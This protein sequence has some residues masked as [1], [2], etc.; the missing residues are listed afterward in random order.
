MN[1]DLRCPPCTGQCAQ[2]RSCPA[3]PLERPALPAEPFVL[4]WSLI[5][6]IVAFWGCAAMIVWS[7]L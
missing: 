2:G 1:D 5:A 6:V 3:K 7:W 4:R